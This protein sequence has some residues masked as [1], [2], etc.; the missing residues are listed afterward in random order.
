[1]KKLLVEDMKG[2]FRIEVPD[3]A[4]CT[5]GPAIP[6]E[7]KSR[8]G[9]FGGIEREYALRIYEGKNDKD[10]PIAV[11]TGVKQFRMETLLVERRVMSEEGTTAW[12]SDENGVRI[13]TARNRKSRM[14]RE[15][16]MLEGQVEEF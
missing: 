16:L 3:E 6:F 9:A 8:S 11:F 2:Y 14:V 13:E 5:F 10:N 7:G 12:K 1:M 15:D 4:R